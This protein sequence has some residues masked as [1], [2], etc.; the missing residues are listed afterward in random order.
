V[1]V[2]VVERPSAT[3][4][5]IATLVAAEADL[6][7]VGQAGSGAEAIAL[8][9]KLRPDVI[10]IDIDLSDLGPVATIAEIMAEAP[11][12]IVVVCTVAA[13]ERVALSQRV[14]AAGALEVIAKASAPSPCELVNWGRRVIE[15]IR[16][17]AKVPVIR[18]SRSPA[19]GAQTGAGA[20]R[21]RVDVFGIA[22]SAGGPSALADVLAR[23]PRDLPFP[24]LVAQHM[25]PGFTV[26]LVALL[27]QSGP[28][29]VMCADSDMACQPGV[30][31][32]P[33]DAHDLLLAAPGVLRVAESR[34]VHIPSCDQLLSSIARCC[35]ARAAGAVLTGMGQDGARGLLAIKQAGGYTYAQDEKT[36][37][38][39][40]MPRAARDLGATTELLPLAGIAAAI[41]ELGRPVKR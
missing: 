11:A 23:L 20:N 8:A 15:S 36:S 3:L 40:G 21:A 37:A 26:G 18:R 41:S 12:R 5:T 19:N 2:L 7:L 4:N 1:R 16:L 27:G 17:M 29:K 35:G 25:T 24:I 14:L 32:L 31:Y 6:A 9:V 10:A 34:G 22:S 38:V 28:L 39:F 33:P 30:V 13:S